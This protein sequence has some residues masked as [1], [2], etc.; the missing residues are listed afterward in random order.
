MGRLGEAYGMGSCEELCCILSIPL[1]SEGQQIVLNKSLR[2]E[3][4]IADNR[5]D[6]QVFLEQLCCNP[7]QTVQMLQQGLDQGRIDPMRHC[8]DCYPT[9]SIRE[10]NRN[11][12]TKQLDNDNENSDSNSNSKSDPVTFFDANAEANSGQPNTELTK[13]EQQELRLADY[14]EAIESAQAICQVD[15]IKYRKAWS[16]FKAED[17]KRT[18]QLQSFDQ[19]LAKMTKEAKEK[20]IEI[21]QP[22][23]GF[24]EDGRKKSKYIIMLNRKFKETSPKQIAVLTEI[25]RACNG[26]LV[27]GPAKTKSR[28]FEK[29]RL[30]YGKNLGRITDYVRFSIICIEVEDMEKAAEMINEKFNIFRVKNRFA[31][32]NDKATAGYRD[33]QFVAHAIGTKLVIELQLHLSCIYAIKSSVANFKDASGRTGHDRYIDFRQIK[34]ETDAQYPE[35]KGN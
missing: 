4:G 27:I 34:E 9:R 23:L 28:L 13:E 30:S 3:E 33:C 11:R 10:A 18:V 24:D 25:A 19:K 32:S 1:C 22:D 16:N 14:T 12:N 2:A 15:I 21:A 31:G 6:C 35:F 7:C 26:K 29:A 17:S 5:G 8:F 20:G